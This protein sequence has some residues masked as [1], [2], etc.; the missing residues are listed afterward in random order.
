[1]NKQTAKVGTIKLLIQLSQQT[2]TWCSNY[3]G[4]SDPI[5][6]IWDGN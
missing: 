5:I 3:F 6:Q 4:R 2:P 1:M